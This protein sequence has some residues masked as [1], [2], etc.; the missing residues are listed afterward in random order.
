MRPEVKA[1]AKATGKIR[2][3]VKPISDSKNIVRSV[4]NLKSANVA[5]PSETSFNG[6]SVEDCFLEFEASHYK[7]IAPCGGSA[8]QSKLTTP[9]ILVLQD[10]ML[11]SNLFC[12]PSVVL[13]LSDAEIKEHHQRANIKELTAMVQRE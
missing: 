12:Q 5:S 4:V 6:M 11:P 2:K 1:K 8:R 13:I 9:L 3:T 10:I 7:M